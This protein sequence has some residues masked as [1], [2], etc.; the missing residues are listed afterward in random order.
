LLN[1]NEI[2]IYIVT[3]Y[4]SQRSAIFLSKHVCVLCSLGYKYAGLQGGYL[5]SCGAS[6][7]SYRELDQDECSSVCST[8]GMEC[9]GA[10]THSIYKTN[11]VG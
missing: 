4:V 2:N 7:G 11:Y 9:G 5:C 6:Y 1:K 3:L 8:D 10:Y